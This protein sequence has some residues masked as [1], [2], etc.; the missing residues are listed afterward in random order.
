MSATNAGVGFQPTGD[1]GPNTGVTSSG[2]TIGTV[3]ATPLLPFM[4]GL[5][6]PYFSQLI[7][8]PILHNAGWLAM[9]TNIPS[10]IPKFE[11]N[12]RE[13]P[14]NHVH[15]FYIWRSSNSIIDDFIRIMLFQHTLTR[16]VAKW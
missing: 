4:V 10:Y 6:L 11:G 9:P 13:D 2:T 7:N 15:S 16:E 14:T 1:S 5:S 3:L 12:T 8:D